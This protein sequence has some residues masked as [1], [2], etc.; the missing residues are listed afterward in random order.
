MFENSLSPRH[1][2][3]VLAIALL[4]S[5][6]AI[7]VGVDAFTIRVSSQT[8]KNKKFSKYSHNIK[9]HQKECSACHT[10][11]SSN[12]KAVRPAADAFPDVTEYP[13]HQSC[14]GCHK[15]QFFRGATPTIC[16]ICHTNP[17]PRGGSRHPFPN[18]RE[19]FDTSAK[20]KSAV[21]DFAIHFPH[22][23]HIEIVSRTGSKRD[24]VF[25]NA[26]YRR[27]GE[28]SCK[29][30]HV[31]Y[32]PQGD[33]SDE[34]ATKPPA[35][36]GDA[37]WLKKGTFK[38]VPTGHSKCFTCHSP[39]TGIQPAPNACSVCH[40][41]KPPEPAS[42]LDPTYPV[43]MGVTDMVIL[44]AWRRRDSSATFRHEWTSHA[45]MECANCHNVATMNTLDAATKRVGISSCNMCHTTA[46]SDDGGA[47]N[48]EVDS[49]RKTPTFQ[50]VKCHIAFGRLPIPESH[51][52]SL[53][54]A[55]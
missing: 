8:V 46:T 37:F 44:R 34:F 32:Q 13:K 29:V 52:K 9:A 50:C 36:L 23:K 7:T 21:S 5:A 38:T 41:P 28:E 19:V 54:E 12:W 4:C 2:I 43:K 17:S 22:D 6:S 1:S 10:F 47:L 20:G 11:P 25:T 16:S 24:V 55:K 30:C 48:Y 14:V 51:I 3:S 49:R 31:T 39:D 35:N 42:D 27:A 26:S 45:E 53:A 40:K 18:P 15:Q 33:S